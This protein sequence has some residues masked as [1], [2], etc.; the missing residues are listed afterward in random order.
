MTDFGNINLKFSCLNL[1]FV[2]AVFLYQFKK[3][4]ALNEVRTSG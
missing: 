2:K 4:Q 3:T 1:T